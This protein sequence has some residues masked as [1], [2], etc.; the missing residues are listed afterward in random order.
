M[1]ALHRLAAESHRVDPSLENFVPRLGI[2][3][4]LGVR[5]NRGH[6]DE[7]ATS[8]SYGDYSDIGPL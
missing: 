8:A 6:I 1:D 4:D 7:R 3:G 2:W 5:A